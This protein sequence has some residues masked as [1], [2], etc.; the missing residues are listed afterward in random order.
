MGIGMG[1][2]LSVP[3]D[4]INMYVNRMTYVPTYL[5]ADYEQFLKKF[6]FSN[7]AIGGRGNL[8]NNL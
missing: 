6:C 5:L 4:S 3:I 7:L 2:K 1:I 8:E